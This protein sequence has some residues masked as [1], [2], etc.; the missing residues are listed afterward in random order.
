MVR[1]ARQAV[2][3]FEGDSVFFLGRRGQRKNEMI[4]MN[5]LGTR[6]AGEQ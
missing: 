5:L 1:W 2:P 4:F 3:I 6:W